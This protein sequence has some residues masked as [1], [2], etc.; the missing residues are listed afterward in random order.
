MKKKQSE[1][2]PYEHNWHIVSKREAV[3]YFTL[4][5]GSAIS[6][7]QRAEKPYK[8]SYAVKSC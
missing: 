2:C 7:Y 8:K 6:K 3:N 1:H 5:R 4:L